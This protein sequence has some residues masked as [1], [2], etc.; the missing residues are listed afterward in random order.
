MELLFGKDKYW[1][2]FPLHP[3]LKINYLERLYTKS[4][5]KAIVRQGVEFEEEEWDLNKKTYLLELRRSNKEKQV[6]IIVLI[7]FA[8]SWFNVL[9]GKL[10][11]YGEFQALPITV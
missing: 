4:Q 9:Q 5:L 3:A 2:L 7:I 6:S 10:I 1:W 8:F 11:D